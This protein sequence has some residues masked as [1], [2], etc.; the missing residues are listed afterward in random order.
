MVKT[1][2]L[3]YIYEDGTKALK[4]I[5]LNI[6]NHN[7]IGIVGANGSGKTTLFFNLMGLLKPSKGKVFL[8]GKEMKYNRKALKKI[9]KKIGIV[10]Q[11]PDKQI[12]YSK[13]YDDVAFGPRNLG[14]GEEEV[15][16]IVEN[17]LNMVDMVEFKD[18]P[19]HFLS[20]G[21]KK[22]VAIAGALAMNND[23]ILFD[24]P[25]AGLDPV[26][27]E[28]M[29]NIIKK[30]SEKNKKII[31][32]SHDMDMIY[33][34]CEYI[35]I[36]SKGEV[37]DEGIPTRIFM[38]ESILKEAMLKE[39]WLVKIHKILGV[40]LCEKEEELKAFYIGKNNK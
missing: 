8:N 15:N 12:F 25:T 7:I 3:C 20:Y 35:Y 30:L 28:N 29:I 5:N 27:T 4:N 19:V 37:I 26:G 31:I 40:P 6:D 34:L 16:K 9:R 10:F 23:I 2:G 24:E 13:V 11:D 39:P 14:I 36:M 32:S 1:Q 22:K 21:Q 17:A 18:K 38:K 33:E